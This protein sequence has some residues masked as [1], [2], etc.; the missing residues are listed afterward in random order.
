MIFHSVCTIN[1][2][3]SNGKYQ[4]STAS[5][6]LIH[7]LQSAIRY[8]S[9]KKPS[10]A[11][12]HA[13]L[14]N[15]PVEV[16]FI[17]YRNLLPQDVGHSIVSSNEKPKLV[18]SDWQHLQVALGEEGTDYKISCR[19]PNLSEKSSQ[20]AEQFETSSFPS[21]MKSAVWNCTCLRG[22]IRGQSSVIDSHTPTRLLV[23]PLG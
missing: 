17:V 3:D 16:R 10:Q 5:L 12:T 20:S 9:R 7:L 23:T 2:V 6:S 13:M 14:L 8:S 4:R 21:F 22:I 18:S 1:L 11:I 19:S 15:L